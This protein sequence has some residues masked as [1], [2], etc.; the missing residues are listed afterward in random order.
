MKDYSGYILAAYG[1]AAVLIGF[2]VGKIALDY[3]ELKQKLER[4]GDEGKGL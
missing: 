4:F 3:R 1:F 2:I